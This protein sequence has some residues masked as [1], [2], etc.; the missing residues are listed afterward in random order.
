[1][2]RVRISEDMAHRG[3]SLVSPAMVRQSLLPSYRRWVSEIRSTGCA[4][5]DIDS[6]GYIA[7][8]IPL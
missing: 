8:L 1:V 4:L 2:D 6:D 7:D 3:Y 5:I